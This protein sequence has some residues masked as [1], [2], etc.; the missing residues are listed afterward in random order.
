MV[1]HGNCTYYRA[2]KERICA[3]NQMERSHLER[4]YRGIHFQRE[5]LFNPSCLSRASRHFP[6]YSFHARPAL[7]L[8]NLTFVCEH[9]LISR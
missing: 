5:D 8:S 3:G 4:Y 6:L 7:E 9:S 1:Q 2:P